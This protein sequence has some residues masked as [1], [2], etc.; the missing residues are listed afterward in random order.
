[1]NVSAMRPELPPLTCAVCGGTEISSR[2]KEPGGHPLVE[3]GR[4][5]VWSVHDPPSPES[6]RSRYV[7]DYYLPWRDEVHARR[8]MWRRRLR[9]LGNARKGRLLDVGCA[10]GDFL[11]QASEAG[12]TVEGTELSVHGARKTSL[13]LGVP[14]HCGELAEAGLP[15]GSF[16]VVTFWHVLEHMLHPG[17]ALGEARRILEPDGLLVVAVPNRSNPLFRAAYRIARGR[18]LYLYHPKDREQHLHHWSPPSLKAALE[19]RGFQVQ[20]LRPDPCALGVVKS[21]LDLAGRLHSL[22]AGAPRTQAMVALARAAS[23][24]GTR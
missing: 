24:G 1:M 6:L 9:L 5:G 20:P 18:P 16:S 10:E 13:G 23:G 17:R 8:R 19:C 22:L 15:A 7:E 14:V 3:C 4:C 2:G 21:A 11:A 12:F